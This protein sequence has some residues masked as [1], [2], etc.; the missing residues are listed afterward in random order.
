ME[1]GK[2]TTSFLEKKPAIKS[3]VQSFLKNLRCFVSSILSDLDLSGSF[4]LLTR[5]SRGRTPTNHCH[6]L[7]RS[8]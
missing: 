3:Q 4:L 7:K 2:E 6:K 5:Y 1:S 8:Q